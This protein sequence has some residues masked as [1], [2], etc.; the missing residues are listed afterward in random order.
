MGFLRS[1][2]YE[3]CVLTVW[4]VVWHVSGFRHWPEWR[5]Q[6]HGHMAVGAGKL[7]ST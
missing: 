3:G 5:K 2:R 7:D 1:V 6:A 4:N